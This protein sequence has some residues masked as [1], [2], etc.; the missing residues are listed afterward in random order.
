VP[1]LTLPSNN[2][3]I[4]PGVVT[5]GGGTVPLPLNVVTD[6]LP[7][8]LA[9]VSALTI[10][11]ATEALLGLLGSGMLTELPPVPG[12]VTEAAIVISVSA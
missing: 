1:P 3:F 4:A 9:M 5:G 6:T 2:S 10:C 7:E 12:I 11:A 8:L